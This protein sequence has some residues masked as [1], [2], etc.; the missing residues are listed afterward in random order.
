[1]GR[2]KF[3]VSHVREM[4]LAMEQEKVDVRGYIHWSLFDNFEWAEGFTARFGLAKVDYENGFQ[5][6]ER[7]SAQVYRDIAKA[8]ALSPELAAKLGAP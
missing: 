1:V 8:N 5:R 6:T 7:P 4:W 2:Q 3:L